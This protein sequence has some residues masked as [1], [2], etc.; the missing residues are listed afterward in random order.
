MNT[1]NFTRGVPANESFPTAELIDASTAAFTSHGNQMLQ[2]GPSRGFEPLRQWLAEWQRV[3]VD[4][5]ITA[6]GSLQTDRVSLPAHDQAGRPRF[7]RVPQL[8]PH[9]RPLAASW[10]SRRRDPDGTGWPQHRCA[11]ERV[12]EGRAQVLLSDSRLPEPGGGH[13][14]GQQ[15]PADRRVGLEVRGSA[16]RGRALPLAPV[17]RNRGADAVRAGARSHAAHELVHEAHCA[18]RSHR[19]HAR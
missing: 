13:L 19:L 3:E 2:Y 5:V 4:R 12:E 6:N 14:F 17:S 9:A 16:R 10:R 11:R 7:H 18:R 15:A 8:R 1:I